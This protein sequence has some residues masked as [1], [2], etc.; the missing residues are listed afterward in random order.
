MDVGFISSSGGSGGGFSTLDILAKC[1]FNVWA[2]SN[3]CISM[4]LLFFKGGGGFL[5]FLRFVIS[6]ATLYYCFGGV[7]GSDNV[8][9]NL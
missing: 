8:F 9:F 1:L 5:L 6:F 7:L 3:G 2:L 4:V